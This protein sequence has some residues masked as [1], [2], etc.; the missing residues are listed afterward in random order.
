MNWSLRS[1]NNS[2]VDFIYNSWL[3]SYRK[4]EN[5]MTHTVYYDRFKKIL[6][7]IFQKSLVIIACDQKDPTQI[8]GYIV[9]EPLDPVILHYVY[10]KFMYRQHGIGK[11]LLEAV[12]KKEEPVVCTFANHAF[13]KLKTKWRL[14]YNPWL[15]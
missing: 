4:T 7:T 10:V 15:R 5:K 14:T 1:P 3:E 9:Y 11:D 6:T 13:T 8:F 2:D 12:R